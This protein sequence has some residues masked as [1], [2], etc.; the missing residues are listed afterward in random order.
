MFEVFN[1][2]IYYLF[3]RL[4]YILAVKMID[5]TSVEK[6]KYSLAGVII[7]RV[8]DKIDINNLVIRNTSNKEFLLER[9]K[10]LTASQTVKLKSF[11]KSSK[12]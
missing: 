1:I 7:K 5:Y 2:K 11:E 10:L 4:P 8:I 3:D 12:Y 9:D 6:I